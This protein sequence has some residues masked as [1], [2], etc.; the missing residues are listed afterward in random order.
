[1][2]GSHVHQ[3]SLTSLRTNDRAESGIGTLIVFIAMILVAAVA[4]GVLV[5]T[6][7]NL[8]QQAESTGSEATERV[9]TGLEV[10]GVF[11][12]RN[13]TVQ[14]RIDNITMT[15]QLASGSPPVDLNQLKLRW[16]D[17]SNAKDINFTSGNTPTANSTYSVE[18]LRDA[19]SSYSTT[20]PVVNGNDLIKIHLSTVWLAPRTAVT[21][22]LVPEGG[23]Q[24]PILFT[25][26]NTYTTNWIT[27]S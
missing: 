13:E 21:A 27:L 7:T 9:A 12:Q 6:S 5:R 24:T 23:I 17:G 19:D 18:V 25:T 14:T 11:G 1:M 2:R 20:A 22:Y 16:S 8:Q 26:P 15:L 10:V 3:A 4:A